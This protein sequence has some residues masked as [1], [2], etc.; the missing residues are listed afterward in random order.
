[1]NTRFQELQ[2]Y[3]LAS[4]LLEPMAEKE[5]TARMRILI[6]GEIKY[7]GSTDGFILLRNL[8][9]MFIVIICFA[10]ALVSL[11]VVSRQS[12]RLIENVQ[13]GITSRNEIM[14]QRA[15]K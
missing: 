10:A 1:M 8:L 11:A 12:S 6:P 4:V 2:D 14:L 13:K 7:S 5:E 15:N 3:P 9:V